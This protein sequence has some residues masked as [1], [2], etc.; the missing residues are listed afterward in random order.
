MA[1]S[2]NNLHIYGCYVQKKELGYKNTIIEA[3]FLPRH[4]I[5]YAYE[6]LHLQVYDF[7]RYVVLQLKH[8]L[9]YNEQTS[10]QTNYTFNFIVICSSW[11]CG[12][13]KKKGKNTFS[14]DDN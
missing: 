13:K 14:N 4:S 12:M 3:H 6:H 11:W 9:L 8:F 7:G 5:R 1:V 2:V 10:L